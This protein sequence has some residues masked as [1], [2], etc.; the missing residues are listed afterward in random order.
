MSDDVDD[1]IDAHDNDD[2]NAHADIRSLGAYG[3]NRADAAWTLANGLTNLPTWD[4]GSNVP[5]RVFSSNFVLWV[6][7]IVP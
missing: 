7:E 3:S 1:A 5:I 4:L 6:E 2:P